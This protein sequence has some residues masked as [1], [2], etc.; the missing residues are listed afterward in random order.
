MSK[1]MPPYSAKLLK[2]GDL[3]IRYKDGTSKI[4]PPSEQSNLP[5]PVRFDG[6][7]YSRSNAD[8]TWE[9]VRYGH[10]P[11]ELLTRRNCEAIPS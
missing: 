8:G 3:E 7:G 9:F 11:E 2:G 4:Y 6:I 10:K 1:T 5:E